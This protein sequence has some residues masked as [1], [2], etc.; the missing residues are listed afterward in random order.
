MKV[1]SPR[2]RYAYDE[3]K[4]GNFITKTHRLLSLALSLQP[5]ASFSEIRTKRLQC[6]QSRT[7]RNTEFRRQAIAEHLPLSTSGSAELQK[8]RNREARQRR[9]FTDLHRWSV[10]APLN[11]GYYALLATYAYIVRMF[12]RSWSGS[13][14][15]MNA[16]VDAT[17]AYVASAVLLQRPCCSS[18][19]SEYQSSQLGFGWL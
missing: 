17:N 3:G 13:P 11:A 7:L 6:S 4:Q 16:S 8:V 1:S 15:G 5:R 18:T 9:L 19:G 12:R 10:T 2:R 14:V